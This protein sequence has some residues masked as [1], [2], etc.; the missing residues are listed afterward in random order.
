MM[1]Q[2]IQSEVEYRVIQNGV[3]SNAYVPQYRKRNKFWAVYGSWKDC[4]ENKYDGRGGSWYNSSFSF[5]SLEKA[6]QF[7]ES[8]IKRNTVIIY[9]K[10]SWFR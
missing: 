5:D 4:T 9:S 8:E 2:T 6:T 7:V 10:K 3:G 1:T